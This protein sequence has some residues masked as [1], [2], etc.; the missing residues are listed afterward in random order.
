MLST[1]GFYR[2]PT[3]HLKACRRHTLYLEACRRHA[4]Y[5]EACPVVGGMSCRRTHT[6]YWEASFEACYLNGGMSY[7]SRHVKGAWK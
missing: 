2:R 6:L 4:L 5:F 1:H 3:P 7:S